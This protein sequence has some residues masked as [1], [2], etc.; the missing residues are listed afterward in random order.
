MGTTIFSEMTELARRTG[1]INLG[2]G[3]PDE[4]GPAEIL[5]AA[6]A[7][8]RAGHNQYAPLPG[9]PELRAAVADHQ[10][11]H[12]GIELDPDTEV[13]VTFGATE[14]LAAALLALVGAGDEVLA[15][16]PA[17]DSYGPI[18]RL[19]GG[20][21]QPDR[22]GAAGLA[23]RRRRRRG[24]RRPGRAGAAAQLAAQPDRARARRRRARAAGAA[25]PRARPDRDHRRGLRAPRL[26]RDPR[27]A[28]DAARHARAHPD[29]F[30]ARQDPLA[31]R[32]EDR[33]GDRAGGAGRA[34][35]LRQAVPHASPAAR[36]CSTR[37][38]S[39][40]RS[41]RARWPRRCGPSATGSRPGSRRPDSTCFRRAG[42]YFLNATLGERDAAEICK[43][44]PH[45]AG[46]AAIPVSA[47]SS[48]PGGPVRPIVRFAFCKRD[49]VLDQAAERL[50]AWTKGQVRSASSGG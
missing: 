22:A 13:Q 4:D 24:R 11:R 46:V 17:Y 9:V 1:A 16:D 33:L 23:R 8:L 14:G 26:R 38:L 5:E 41:T 28:G 35:A 2:Q 30:V 20:R 7:A 43:A 48:D 49:E 29:G 18:A 42:T 31:D 25:V 50:R 47:F 12:Y 21:V 44:L 32:L 3:Y 19:A 6:A 37:R 34:R 45:E 10:R 39:A 15:L 27:A 36:R 40:S